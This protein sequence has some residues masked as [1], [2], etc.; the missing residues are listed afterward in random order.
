MVEC[1]GHR[2]IENQLEMSK[3]SVGKKRFKDTRP[4]LE[5]TLH[6]SPALDTLIR[7]P[8]LSGFGLFV[9]NF[10]VL[11]HAAAFCALDAYR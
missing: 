1:Q 5:T 7:R 2:G 11:Y 10:D 6:A 8:R 9:T 3:L 4:R